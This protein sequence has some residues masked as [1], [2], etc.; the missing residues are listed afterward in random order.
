MNHGTVSGG[1]GI[2]DNI[3]IPKA[4]TSSTTYTWR[5][6]SG[7]AD[8]TTASNWSPDRNSIANTDVLQF[9]Q[10]GTSTATNVPN[11]T[12]GQIKVSNSTTINLQAASGSD[13]TLTVQ[14]T[15][16]GDDV[17]V[18]GTSSLNIVS[19]EE[20]LI[21]LGSGATASISGDMTMSSS[22]SQSPAHR[23]SAADASAITFNN[24]STFTAENLGG[25]P[26]DDVV[27]GSVIFASGSE[28]VQNDGSS[29]FGNNDVAV[30]NSGSTFTYNLHTSPSIAGKTFGDLVFT[31]GGTTNILLGS[32]GNSV[33]IDNLTIENGTTV[34]VYYTTNDQDLDWNI[35]GDFTIESNA[36]FNFNPTE[37]SAESNISFNGTSTQT[38]SNSGTFTIGANGN[39]VIDGTDVQLDDDLTVGGDLTNKFW[40]KANHSG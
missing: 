25:N 17:T 23:F 15:T 30:F 24:G 20:L 3:S 5:A 21:T 31:F 28:F 34:N 27:A 38:I 11:E 29:P 22:G 1:N 7:T 32:T 37:S 16:N 8:F 40:K 26:F 2:F 10:G 36:T 33:S 4:A 35:S 6:T 13:K 9:N 18:D 12:V 14:G 39:V 19:D